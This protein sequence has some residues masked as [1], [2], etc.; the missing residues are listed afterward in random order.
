[1]AMLSMVK[2]HDAHSST[3]ARWKRRFHIGI[4]RPGSPVMVT[5]LAGSSSSSSLHYASCAD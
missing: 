5:F 4:A 2:E 1:M 3:E